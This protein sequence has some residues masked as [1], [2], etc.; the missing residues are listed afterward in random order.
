MPPRP[1][2]GGGKD[3]KMRGYTVKK[4]PYI[5]MYDSAGILKCSIPVGRRI[6]P[7]VITG[8]NWTLKKEFKKTAFCKRCGTCV[9]AGC[10]CGDFTPGDV[11]IREEEL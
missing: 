8:T 5:S 1:A 6:T 10:A 2:I 9:D 11:I 4:I 7:G 3:K